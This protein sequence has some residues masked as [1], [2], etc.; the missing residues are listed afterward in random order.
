MSRH[1]DRIDALVYMFRTQLHSRILKTAAHRYY[2]AYGFLAKVMVT[3][4]ATLLWAMALRPA[5]IPGIVGWI[6]LVFVTYLFVRGRLMD[7]SRILGGHLDARFF[8]PL[9]KF[10]N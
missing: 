9:C 7:A 5:A 6:L 3:A 8:Q 1:D 4:F 2:W 10:K